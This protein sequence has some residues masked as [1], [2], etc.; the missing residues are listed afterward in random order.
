SDPFVIG[1]NAQLSFFAYMNF[2]TYGSDGVSVEIVGT[3][4]TVRVDYLGSGGALLSFIVGW[5]EYRYSFDDTPFQPGDTVSIRFRF[6][7]DSEDEEQGV[8]IDDVK[9]ICA[10][11]EFTTSVG[12]SSEL[13]ER[14][15]LEVFPNPFNASLSIRVEGK[16]S[17]S[18]KLAIFDIG[19]RLVED[20]TISSNS[21]V[22]NGI[23]NNG[24]DAPSGLYFI[25]LIDG[26]RVF[27]ARA[28]LLK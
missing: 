6:S 14:I 28:V 3:H 22:W 7:S 18:A 19:G 25:R 5:A 27:T 20:L 9:L 16:I 11:T 10:S 17:S 12:V 21:I 1:A 24:N 13:P 4:E 2:P 23:D 8:F 15:G 26:D